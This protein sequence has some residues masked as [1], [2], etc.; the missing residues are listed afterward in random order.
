MPSIHACSAYEA[1]E[2][3]SFRPGDGPPTKNFGRT[4]RPCRI[5]GMG[6]LFF[7]AKKA[8][9]VFKRK[10]GVQMRFMRIFSA[11]G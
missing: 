1:S 2:V 8:P 3:L 6:G 4:D 7:G 5:P 11:D 9:P 10:Q